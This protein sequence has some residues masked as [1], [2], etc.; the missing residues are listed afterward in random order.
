MSIYNQLT[1]L[2]FFNA[3]LTNNIEYNVTFEIILLNNYLNINIVCV[4]V[5]S[6]FCVFL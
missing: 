5:K 6:D 1:I 4:C 2:K 3:N